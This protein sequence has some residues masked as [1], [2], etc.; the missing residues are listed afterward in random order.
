MSIGRKI[1]ELRKEKDWS[2]NELAKRARTRPHVISYYENDK[3]VPSVE[4]L[5]KLANAFGVPL[6]YLVNGSVSE[7]AS[8]ELQDREL[9][10]FFKKVQSLDPSS[11]SAFKDV[12]RSFILGKQVSS[13]K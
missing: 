10:E 5:T 1:R 6:D 9:L 8:A 3:S 13:L 7:K 2:Q 4:G 12:V 11:K